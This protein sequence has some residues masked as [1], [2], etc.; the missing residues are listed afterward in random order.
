[1]PLSHVTH[2]NLG[3]GFGGGERQCEL[4]I[5]GL[6]EL[7]VPQRLVARSS[8]LRRRVD[9]LSGVDLVRAEHLPFALVGSLGRTSL[10]HAHDMR[11][12]RA[13]MLRRSLGGPPF[14]VT[15]RLTDAP[16]SD[17]FDRRVYRRAH[18]LVAVSQAIVDAMQAYEPSLTPVLI[19]SASTRLMSD[20]DKVARLRRR[21]AGKVVVGC[22]G[23]LDDDQKGQMMLVELARRSLGAR[24]RL[25]FL[26]V[27][28]GPDRERL[29]AAAGTLANIEFTGWVEDVGNY[30]EAF[31]ILACPARRE[32]TGSAV[33]D[34]MHAGLAVVASRVGGLLELVPAQAGRLFAPGDIDALG[35]ALFALAR[36][37]SGRAA[38]GAAGRE[39]AARFTPRRMVLSYLRLYGALGF[40]GPDLSGARGRT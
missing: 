13:A 5:T 16:R 24:P 30:L 11:A 2:V 39:H 17:A 34:A 14:V 38:M 20:P 31:D 1:M 8:I 10:L 33:L 15:H 29:R 36:D 27:G 21:Y 19:P 3:D 28:D 26:L 22:V 9:G 25:H 6:S 12:A 7:G 35:E 32:T 23:A 4:L 18:R 37:E 40:A